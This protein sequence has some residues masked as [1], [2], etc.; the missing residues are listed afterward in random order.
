MGGLERAVY[1]PAQVAVFEGVDGALG[2]AVRR[3]HVAPKLLCRLGTCQRKL[4]GAQRRLLAKCLGDLGA[5]PEFD[6]AVLHRF[7]HEEKVGR[8]A[9]RQGGDAVDL[10]FGVDPQS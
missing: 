1:E 5:K 9:A 7:E 6:G 3:G 2:G 10:R 4:G 8:S